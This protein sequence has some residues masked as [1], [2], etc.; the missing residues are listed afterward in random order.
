MKKQSQNEHLLQFSDKSDENVVCKKTYS[1]KL[2]FYNTDRK[3]EKYHLA[4]FHFNIQASKFYALLLK[5]KLL[6]SVRNFYSSQWVFEIS[7]KVRLLCGRTYFFLNK[8][9]SL[10]K[11]WIKYVHSFHRL[12][13]IVF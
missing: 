7:L 5:N 13:S 4:Y 8:S 2:E 3:N 10:T 1:L 9:N 11:S 6:N 12:F